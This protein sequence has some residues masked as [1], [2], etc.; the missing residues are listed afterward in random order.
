MTSLVL[1]LLKLVSKET[2]QLKPILGCRHRDAFAQDQTGTPCRAL[3]W[4]S[5]SEQD[6]S[7][8]DVRTRLDQAVQL[9]VAKGLLKSRCATRRCTKQT[10]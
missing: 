10:T 2:Q 5:V 9:L 6:I 8:S 4:R 1:R 3:R 7:D